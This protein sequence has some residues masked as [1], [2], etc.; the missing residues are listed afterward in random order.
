MLV[1]NH[2]PFQ[3]CPLINR[4]TDT[5]SPDDPTELTFRKGEILE[6]L[7]KSDL[8]W[9]A[10]K[11]DGAIGSELQQVYFKANMN[12]LLP[13]SPLPIISWQWKTYLR[14]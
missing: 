8:W 1:C 5:A 3:L 14:R 2:L 6:I 13:Q 10:R 4:F 12:S 9:E 7:T 11:A